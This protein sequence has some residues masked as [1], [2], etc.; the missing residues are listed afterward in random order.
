MYDRIYYNTDRLYTYNDDIK[1]T[2]CILEVF[3]SL[4]N[5]QFCL[6]SNPNGVHQRKT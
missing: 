6:E 1:S 5:A 2:D 3:N 4:H